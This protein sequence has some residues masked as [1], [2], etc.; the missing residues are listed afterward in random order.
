M[1]AAAVHPRPVRVIVELDPGMLTPLLQTLVQ[2]V[3]T[4]LTPRPHPTTPAPTEDPDDPAPRRV[5]EH[6]PP[7]VVATRH[8][9]MTNAPTLPHGTILGELCRRGHRYA[10]HRKSLR[11]RSNGKCIACVTRQDRHRKPARPP[12][13]P[14]RPVLVPSAEGRPDLPSHWDGRGFLSAIVCA[15]PD[16]RFRGSPW[17]LRYTHNELCVQ[18]CTTEPPAMVGD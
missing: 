6:D 10:G 18:C 12:A 1:Q 5:P 16:H 15:N 4:S 3:T 14:P 2:A 8:Q 7:V 11:R 17:T 13:S 9:S